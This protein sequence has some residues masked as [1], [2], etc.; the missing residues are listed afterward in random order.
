VWK[1]WNGDNII[2]GRVEVIIVVIIKN[3]CDGGE[4]EL[5]IIIIIIRMVGW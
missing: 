1:W 4:G 2:I 5:I 3:W